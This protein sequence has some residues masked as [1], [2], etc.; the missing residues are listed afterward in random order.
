MAFNAGEIVGKIKAD[1]SSFKQGVNSIKTEAKSMSSSVKASF[2][3]MNAKIKEVSPQ[4]RKASAG[5]AVV[6][7]A[8]VLAIKSWTNAFI[9]QERAE[10]R[11][12]QVT[13]QTTGA[14]DE[15]IKSLKDQAAALQKV[16]VIGDEVTI[17]GQS[18][19]ATFALQ[20]DAIAQLTPAMLDMAVAT[21]G[22]NAGQQDMIDIGN[23]VGK[24]M[25]GQV[26]ALS[27][28]GVTF[29]EAQAK[30]LKTGT[31]MER[32]A[33][34]A[35]ILNQNFGGLN[36]TARGTTEGGIKA[37]TNAWG[38]FKEQLGGAIA[39]FIV[40]FAG[41]F[42]VLS[43]KLQGVNPAII[44]FVA[45]GALIIT[46]LAA[47]AAPFL[48]LVSLIPAFVAGLGMIGTAFAFL[49]GPIGLIIALA[50]GLF[51]AW[52]LN[53]FGVQDLVQQWVD[54]II[55]LIEN[56]KWMWEENFFGISTIVTTVFDAI[57]LYFDFWWL[58][59]KELF[60]IFLLA[61]QGNWSGVWDKMK[62]I[63]KL[64]F[65]NIS[66]FGKL[67]WEALKTIFKIGG[68]LLLGAWDGI[69]NGM[70]QAVM[71]TFEGIK[72]AIKDA[73]NWMITKLNAFIGAI[74]SVARFIPGLSRGKREPAL[75]GEIPLLAKGG[76]V[77]SPTLAM[78]GEAGPE[79]VVPLSKMGA[80]GGVT[81]GQGAFDGAIIASKEVAK[82]LLGEAL[83]DMRP[84]LG[85]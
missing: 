1:I 85:I 80:M 8:G 63:A 77:N 55:I 21:K 56:L 35:E 49:T 24:V 9:E 34:L 14:T 71:T 75:I 36:E 61:V 41:M 27:R 30:I 7:G 37:M 62:N 72:N 19:L 26:G 76:I 84:N 13:R 44:K 67:F 53:L 58:A 43:E 15:Q 50:A 42:Q 3:S 66:A 25:G 74:N 78:I 48:L 18:Q 51:A 22:V 39:P 29:S 12:A 10:A 81:F 68:E 16:G 46:A 33:A 83:R 69:M 47:I 40:E 82:E 59:L 6:A 31:E 54:F 4:L 60:S 5:L 32:A 57:K 45:V 20:T 17:F 2:S 64:A 11:L 52:N 38:D 79:A 73:I 23:M 70:K 28:V 65:D